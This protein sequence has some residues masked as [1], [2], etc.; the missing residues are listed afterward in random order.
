MT[1]V[2]VDHV[3]QGR[4]QELG[5]TTDVLVRALLR[6][7]AEAK[8]T[9]GL[10]PPTAAGTT[11]YNKTVGFL[12][13]ELLPF[14]WQ[15]DNARNFCRTIHPSGAF[16][17]VTS[18][19][20]EFTGVDLPG[21]K[22]TTKY[23]RGDLTAL[24]VHQNADQGVLDLGADFDGTD[25]PGVLE[26]I[27]FLL[28]RVTRDEIYAELSLPTAIEGGLIVDWEERIILPPTSRQDPAPTITVEEPPTGDSDAYTVDVAAR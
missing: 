5:L 14:G 10:E 26:S 22:P 16:S 11:R 18:S 8:L 3:A 15:F 9:T 23:P 25:E 28:Q 1:V 20:D 17:V 19:G 21:M 6:A 24:A 2:A 7:D 27:W 4:L 12:R 13:E